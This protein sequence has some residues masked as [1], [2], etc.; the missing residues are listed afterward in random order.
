MDRRELLKTIAVLTGS[1]VI[2]GELFL[3]GCTTKT[4][5]VFVDT[6]PIITDTST[7]L[8]KILT[9]AQV[10]LLNEMADTII[11]TTA[12]SPGAKAAKVGEFMNVMVTDCY[13]PA[14]QKIFTDGLASFE[15]KCMAKYKKNFESLSPAERHDFIISLEKEAKPYDAKIVED[16]KIRE[17]SI[18]KENDISTW[19]KRKEFV[20]TG[21][22]PYTM[23]KQLTLLGYFTSEI[24]MTKARRHVPVPGKYDGAI[25]YNAGDKAWSE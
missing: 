19:A 15:T 2:G 6:N 14:N 11:P 1:A 5:E 8:P 20:P 9:A 12:D 4:K 22:H 10:A 25:A 23:V 7:G 17:S 18:N 3:S 21:R 16:D 13:L 24:G